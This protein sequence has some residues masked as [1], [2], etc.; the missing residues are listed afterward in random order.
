[1][2]GN[3][4]GITLLALVITIVII[5]LL[6][7]ITLQMSMGENGL[8]AKSEQAKKEQAKTELYDT[9]KSSYA[10]LN[11]RAIRNDKDKPN[12]E[13]V[14]NT[15]DFTDRYNIVGDNITDKK[16]TVI[17]TKENVVN[18][19]KLLNVSSTTETPA[20]GT[21]PSGKKIVGGVEIPDVDKDKLII[22]INIKSN[23][24]MIFGRLGG[25]QSNRR[26][27]VKIEY[28]DGTEEM[29]SVYSGNTKEYEPGEYIV[30]FSGI[31][32]YDISAEYNGKYDIEI[33][34]W[35][36]IED[37]NDE[38]ILSLENVSK[39]YEP[40]PDKV[41]ITYHNAKF[42]EIPGW[43][44]SKKVTSTKMS[45]FIGDSLGASLI[46][47]IPEDL[48]KSCINARDFSEIFHG[49]DSIKEI[50]E[51]LFRHNVNATK[52]SNSFRYCQRLIS[53]PEGLFKHNINV[54][55]FFGTFGDC[56]GITNIP[57]GLFKNN[58]NVL[59][60]YATFADCKKV[61]EIPSGLFKNNTNVLN[62]A[63]TFKGCK[64]IKEIP[65]EL[66]KNNL[67]VTD[68][69]EVFSWC[70]EIKEIPEKLFENN[71]KVEIFQGSFDACKG[72]IRIPENA[73]KY[74]ENLKSTTKMFFNCE[75]LTAIPNSLIEIGKKV[76][77]R[78]GNT[79]YMF[80]GCTSA[81]NYNS[82]PNYMN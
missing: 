73:F 58:V 28:E 48:F 66:F 25:I 72:L 39:I 47:K 70:I 50:P 14:F 26:N 40:E 42:T 36:N 69:N 13:E 5:L 21:S 2:M 32:N 54:T 9:V 61:K 15:A 37:A 16:G 56:E 68:F 76:R 65:N 57:N 52:F 43:L 55:D 7:G 51:N 38:N 4:K 27:P 60:F 18:M 8:I 30:K 80:S 71:I 78:G 34:Q 29:T 59:Y 74:N 24:T 1:M 44:F 41:P 23:T 35:G 64:S 12:V 49:C 31:S 6:A 11:L 20:V 22:K 81:S 77:E 19:L 17:D 75:K 63:R 67:N 62:F 79:N 53:I 33:L 45:Q 10:A 82:I 46:E 3:K